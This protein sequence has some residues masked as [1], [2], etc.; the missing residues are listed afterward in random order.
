MAGGQLACL[1]KTIQRRRA[2]RRGAEYYDKGIMRRLGGKPPQAGRRLF[3][4]SAPARPSSFRRR[5]MYAYAFGA[6]ST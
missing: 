5:L 3:K 4:G 6:A 1:S 2:E